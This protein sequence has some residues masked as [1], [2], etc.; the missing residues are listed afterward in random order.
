M[1]IGFL[2]QLKMINDPIIIIFLVIVIGYVM[3]EIYFGFL[4][5]KDWLIHKYKLF[6]IGWRL[7]RAK[8][9]HIKALGWKTIKLVFW[10]TDNPK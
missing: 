9:K 6:M 1:V 2:D 7:T 10:E 3:L 8:D 4:T 5:F